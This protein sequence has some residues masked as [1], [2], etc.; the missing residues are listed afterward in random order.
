ML[1]K[2]KLHSTQVLCEDYFTDHNV[3]AFKLDELLPWPWNICFLDDHYS[4]VNL[5]V[6]LIQEHDMNTYMAEEAYLQALFTS[7]ADGN[8]M[9][10]LTPVAVSPRKGPRDPLGM[11]QFGTQIQVLVPLLG[12]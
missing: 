8:E 1:W 3:A 4:I 10:F 2:L 9:M 7:I 5:T 6:R 11:K 12:I